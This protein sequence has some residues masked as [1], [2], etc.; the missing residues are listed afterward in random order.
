LFYDF[1]VDFFEDI[2]DDR[3]QK[4]IDELL[5]WWNRYVALGIYG[6]TNILIKVLL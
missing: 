1:I 4:N 3:A 6:M 5:D 2:E